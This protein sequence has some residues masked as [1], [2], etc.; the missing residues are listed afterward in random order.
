ME[1]Q[2]ATALEE[3]RK[4]LERII[5]EKE[6]ALRVRGPEGKLRCV[7]RGNRAEYY[8]R[9]DCQ[10]TT[11]SYLPTTSRDTAKFLAQRSYDEVVLKY[12]KEELRKVNALTQMRA[13]HNVNQ[14]YERY[15]PL[16]QELVTPLDMTDEQFKQDFLSQ[17]YPSTPR[18]I[19]N[20]QFK[21]RLGITMRSKS[22]TIIANILSDI[23]A[24]Y[25]YEFPIELDGMGTRYTDFL[26]A[27]VRLR[28]IFRWEHYGKMDDPGYA[29]ANLN[30]TL[31]YERSGFFPGI[32]LII[33]HE[34][35]EK[36]L[37]ID[38]IRTIAETYLL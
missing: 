8:W 38:L 11:G 17:K 6:A 10:N 26:T 13:N 4:V 16:R 25:L 37:D 2:F 1:D 32:N 21:S 36:P 14:I 28:K 15:N 30:R 12:A 9:K 22:E 7:Q 23:G 31:A 35:N 24:P 29:A 3:R 19:M 20:S 33:T 27:N 18:Q 34:T 5:A